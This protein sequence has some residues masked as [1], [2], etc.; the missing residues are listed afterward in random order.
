MKEKEEEEDKKA[1]PDKEIIFAK[2]RKNKRHTEVVQVPIRVTAKG[3]GEK[4]LGASGRGQIRV[5]KFAVCSMGHSCLLMLW[6][7]L[8]RP[9][10]WSES[11]QTAV[12][13]MP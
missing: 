5:S 7:I 8:S 11:I 12:T 9:Q 6:Q 3:S 13:K 10:D 1:L 2:A 4:E